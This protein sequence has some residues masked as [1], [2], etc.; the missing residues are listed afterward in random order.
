MTE[1]EK[2][3]EAAQEARDLTLILL[4]L[5]MLS[6]AVAAYTLAILRRGRPAT[7]EDTT[8][9]LANG[10]VNAMLRLS[11][12]VD[13]LDKMLHTQMQLLTTLVGSL[14]TITKTV[15]DGFGR[16]DKNAAEQRTGFVQLSDRVDQILT[17]ATESGAA[18]RT[19]NE[20]LAKIV[21]QLGRI[22]NVT[23]QL[24]KQTPTDKGEILT[25]V[26][27]LRDLFK[28]ISRELQEMKEKIDEYQTSVRS[29]PVGGD[30]AVNGGDP[31]GGTGSD[32]GSATSG[33]EPI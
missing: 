12:S 26:R 20:T 21:E 28:T 2:L 16:M 13:V 30:A 5:L 17:A 19:T 14:D 29:V 33:G 18:N 32:A 8:N 22:E 4:I 9:V 10:L 3:I 31:S 24:V 1:I 27:E 25:E 6:S 7:A 11:N 15:I 23:D